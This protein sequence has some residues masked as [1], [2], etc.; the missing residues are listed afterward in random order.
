MIFI[1]FVYAF[2]KGINLKYGIKNSISTLLKTLGTLSLFNFGLM[3]GTVS[4]KIINAYTLKLYFSKRLYDNI[5]PQSSSQDLHQNKK[6]LKAKRKSH[7][8]NINHNQTYQYWMKIYS[9]MIVYGLD[10]QVHVLPHTILSLSI[11]I[12]KGYQT[13]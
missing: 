5:F 13:S 4:T 8:Q 9:Y 3:F 11:Y 7:V 12:Y 2:I 10:G 6:L 1:I